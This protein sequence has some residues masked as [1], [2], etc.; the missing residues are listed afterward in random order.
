[1]MKKT[2]VTIACT[3]IALLT[4]AQPGSKSTK[5]HHRNNNGNGNGHP[6]GD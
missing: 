6:I 3:L 5:D 2:V 4:F 1:M